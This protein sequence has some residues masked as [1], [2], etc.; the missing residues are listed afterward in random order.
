MAIAA[1]TVLA[2][3]LALG[4][5]WLSPMTWSVRAA[6]L[7]IEYVAWTIGLGA[8]ISSM[9]AASRATPPPPAVPTL[10]VL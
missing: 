9:F 10:S 5:G 1:M 8:A 4:F 2:Q 7:T 3:L 6:G